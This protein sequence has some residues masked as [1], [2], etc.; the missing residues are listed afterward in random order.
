VCLVSC[1]SSGSPS[2]LTSV[3]PEGP[4]SE[5]VDATDNQPSSAASKATSWERLVMSLDSAVIRRWEMWKLR[6]TLVP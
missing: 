5:A 2:T 3:V 1:M 6:A 4:S